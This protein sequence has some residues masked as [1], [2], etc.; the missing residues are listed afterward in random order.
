MVIKGLLIL[1][2]IGACSQCYGLFPQESE[3]RE[4]KLLDGIWDFRAD[5]SSIRNKGLKEKWYTK[6]LKKVILFST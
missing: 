2:F 4:I 3:S 5:N 6:R 1:A